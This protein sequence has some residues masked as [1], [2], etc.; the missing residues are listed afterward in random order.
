MN[1]ESVEVNAINHTFSLGLT[2]NL[3]YKTLQNVIK[4]SIHRDKKEKEKKKKKSR[5]NNYCNPHA[6]LP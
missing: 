2:F 3:F 5:N 4:I 6:F 1:Y